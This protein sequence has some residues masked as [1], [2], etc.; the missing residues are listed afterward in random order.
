MNN[1]VEYIKLCCVKRNTSLRQTAIKSGI[2]A[3]NLSAKMGKN[4]FYLRDIYA[5]AE[6]L[7]ADVRIQFTD[8]KTGK[9]I[10]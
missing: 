5:L 4:S 7:D 8:K 3:Q 10:I 1:I 2:S 9:P 6:A